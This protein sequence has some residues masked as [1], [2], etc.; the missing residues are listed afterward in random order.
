V[1]IQIHK[2]RRLETLA[3]YYSTLK[4]LRILTS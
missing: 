4:D 3:V 1:R 2:H